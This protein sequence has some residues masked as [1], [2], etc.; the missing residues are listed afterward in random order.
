MHVFIAGTGKLATELLHQMELGEDFEVMAWRDRAP[1][2]TTRSIVVHAGSGRELGD[3]MSF[4]Q[5]THSVLIE[6][7]T[8]SAL[9]KLVPAFPVILCPNTNLLMLK[10]MSMI[11]RSGALFKGY[12]I[13]ITESHQAGKTSTPGTAVAMAESLGQTADQI[14][15][16]RNPED[17]N[18]SLQIP[19]EHLGRH[20][21]HRIS[22]QDPACSIVMETRVY[23]ASPYAS[24]VSR[25]IAAAH[26]RALE[27]RVHQINELIENGWV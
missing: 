17:Q 16:I 4:C 15:S 20:A 6:L 19:L 24:G 9:E 21:F 13:H 27:C 11:S 2:M 23:G 1:T 14:V 7:A 18:R 3:L 10:F 22:I 25:I 26:G 12:E 8:G 5:Q